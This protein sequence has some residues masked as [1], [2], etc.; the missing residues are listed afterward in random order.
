M[1]WSIFPVGFED[2][3][4]EIPALPRGGK[5]GVQNSPLFVLKEGRKQCNLARDIFTSLSVRQGINFSPVTTSKLTNLT[6]TPNEIYEEEVDCRLEIR[7]VTDLPE[8]GHPPSMD[9]HQPS[10]GLSPTIPRMLPTIPRKA[11]LSLKMLLR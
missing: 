7:Y 1:F 6:R 8:D 11:H 10:Q 2:F 5:R 4:R 9:G 3:L